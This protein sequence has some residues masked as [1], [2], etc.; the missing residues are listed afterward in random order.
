MISCLLII[1]FVVVGRM[2]Y[3]Y[4]IYMKTDV[5]IHK[6]R[7]KQIGARLR[8]GVLLYGPPGTGKSKNIKFTY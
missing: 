1:F 5:V 6:Y 4:I 2:Y 3:L 7:Y 8:K